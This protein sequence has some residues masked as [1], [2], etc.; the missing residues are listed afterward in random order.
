MRSKETIVRIICCM[1][2]SVRIDDRGSG[3]M[4]KRFDLIYSDANSID[5]SEV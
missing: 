3:F 2:R 4:C 5:V 1:N